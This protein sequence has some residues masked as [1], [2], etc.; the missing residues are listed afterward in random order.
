MNKKHMRIYFR[1]LAIN[2]SRV[3]RQEREI[4]ARFY[5]PERPREEPVGD[6]LPEITGILR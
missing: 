3:V 5:A 2:V 6:N 4:L 1:R